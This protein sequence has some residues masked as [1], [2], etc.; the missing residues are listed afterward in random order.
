MSNW[1]AISLALLNN[2]SLLGIVDA[3]REEAQGRGLVDPWPVASAQTVDELRGC[4]GF[5]GKFALDSDA[6]KI[7]RGLLQLALKK[8]VREMSRSLGRALSDDDVRDEKTYEARLADLRDGC[9]PI[10][11]ADDPIAAA[12]AVANAVP[13]PAIKKAHRHYSRRDQEGI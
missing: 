10:E 9:W 2:S 12:T 8:I 1:S 11:P 13:S 6:T 5:S 4:I 7:P 3:M